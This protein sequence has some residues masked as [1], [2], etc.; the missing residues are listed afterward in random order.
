MNHANSDSK[1]KTSMIRSNWC[2]YSD[3][4]INVKTIP[5]AEAAVASVNNTNN[6]LIFKNCTPFTNCTSE[7]NNT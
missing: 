5:N 2:D 1:F 3:A 4:C 6:K 7:I